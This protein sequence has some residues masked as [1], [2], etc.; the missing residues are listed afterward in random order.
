MLVKIV[1]APVIALHGNGQH[2]RCIIITRFDGGTMSVGCAFQQRLI[3]LTHN[4][5]CRLPG[6]ENV[7]SVIGERGEFGVID[8]RYI[9]NT[10]FVVN[11]N[12][13]PVCKIIIGRNNDV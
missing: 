10:Q 13:S 6:H 9:V 5:E 3:I 12:A 1:F 2:P 7:L 8:E 4:F 11:A